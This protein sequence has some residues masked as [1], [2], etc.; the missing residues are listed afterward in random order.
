VGKKQYL[1]RELFKESEMKVAT[2]VMVVLLVLGLASSANATSQYWFVATAAPGTGASVDQNGAPGVDTI[3]R[4]E[5]I[6]GNVCDWTITMMFQVLAPEAPLAGWAVDLTSGAIDGKLGIVNG[7]FAYNANNTDWVQHPTLV[8]TTGFSPG[9][10]L[11]NANA[12]NF[13]AGGS[14]GNNNLGNLATFTLRK[15]FVGSS[16]NP[17]F[18]NAVTGGY[19]SADVL[20]NYADIQM[21]GQP[22][23]AGGGAAGSDLGFPIQIINFP[24][25]ATLSLLGLGALALIRRRR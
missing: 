6:P 3:L 18:I 15:V 11:L 12:A 4:C 24:E 5:K 22:V 16:T 9:A 19:E 8:P 13:G 21:G 23:V 14:G 17:E 10:I 2:R 20:G 25:P 1:F 7:S